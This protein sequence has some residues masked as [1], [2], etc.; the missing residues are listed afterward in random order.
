M[1]S[2]EGIIRNAQ[3]Q[4]TLSEKFLCIDMEECEGKLW[5]VILK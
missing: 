5:C 3:R 2:L 1:F 4:K